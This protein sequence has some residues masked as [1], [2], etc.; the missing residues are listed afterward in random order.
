M[1]LSSINFIDNYTVT[2]L[3]HDSQDRD[4][5][6]FSQSSVYAEGIGLYKYT[7]NLDNRKVTFTLIE[8]LSPVDWEK[9]KTVA[10]NAYN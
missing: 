1:S 2:Y 10:N 9:I 8:I 4:S 5:V 3:P 7:R 6:Y